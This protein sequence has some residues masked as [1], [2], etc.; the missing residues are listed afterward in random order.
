MRGEE[1]TKTIIHTIVENYN[2]LWR[3]SETIKNFIKKETKSNL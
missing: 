1:V 3:D 2:R